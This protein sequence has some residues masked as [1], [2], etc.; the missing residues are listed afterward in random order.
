MEPVTLTIPDACKAIGLS[1]SSVYELIGEGKLK[2][3]TIAG[4]SL[5]TVA[6]IK[7][8]VNAPTVQ[9]VQ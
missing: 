9:A 3:V 8:L 6:S 4:R 7:S 5:V 1:R 2:K